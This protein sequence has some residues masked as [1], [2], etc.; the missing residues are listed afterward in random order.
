[1]VRGCVRWREGG[2]TNTVSFTACASEEPAA[3]STASRF[4]NACVC[5]SRISFYHTTRGDKSAYRTFP[6]SSFDQLPIG[7]GAD[8]PG[9]EEESVCFYHLGCRMV[10]EGS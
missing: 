10:S 1:M 2:R 7:R 5:P 3:L 9:R 8:L 6:D 4:F